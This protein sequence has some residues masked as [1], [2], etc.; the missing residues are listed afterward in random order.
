MKKRLLVFTA[1]LLV[2]WLPWQI[3]SVPQTAAPRRAERQ[4]VIGTMQS[5][6]SDILQ[7]KRE[8]W[9]YLPPSYKQSSSYTAYPTLYLLDGKKLFHQVTGV[10]KQM[11]ADATPQIPEMIVVGI[12]SQHRVRDSSPT[13]SLIGYEGKPESALAAS[14]GASEFLQF[15]EQELIPHIDETYRTGEYRLFAGYSFTGLPVLHALYTRPQLFS[16]YLAIDPSIWWDDA[17]MLRHLP[18]FTNDAELLHKTLFLATTDRVPVSIW[19]DTN[20]VILFA[21][22]LQSAEVEGL[23]FGFKQYG[24][25]ENHHTMPLISFY[26]G[27]KYVFQGYMLPQGFQHDNT[28]ADMSAHFAAVSE[29]LGTTIRPPENVVDFYAGDLMYS[30]LHP[31]LEAAIDYFVLNTRYY[32]QSFRAWGRLGFAYAE[33]GATDQAIEALQRALM[34]NPD[35]QIISE[36]LAE[37]EETRQ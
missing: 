14:G 3:A 33:I 8:Y 31:D 19:P 36:R 25:E 15:I 6:T 20:Y 1:C 5:I 32:P 37:I 13:R 7:E 21:E 34:L 27:L 4:I 28:A 29:V 23:R 18:E 26:D 12:V 17:V 10:L 11:S 35:S 30:S 16:A 22:R 2:S 9:V 24:S